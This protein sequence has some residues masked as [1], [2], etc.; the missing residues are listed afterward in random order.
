MSAP[1]RWQRTARPVEDWETPAWAVR[2]VEVLEDVAAPSTEPVEPAERVVA[3]TLGLSPGNLATRDATRGIS[4]HDLLV[5]SG[6]IVDIMRQQRDARLV[7]EGEGFTKA[8]RHEARKLTEGLDHELKGC[9]V[10]I[11]RDRSPAG[12]TLTMMKMMAATSDDPADWLFRLSR[13]TGGRPLV[14][15]DAT[16]I[17]MALKNLEFKR[18]RG[19]LQRVRGAL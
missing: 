18:A 17:V 1:T 9:V 15:P 8:E 3:R 19:I 13:M 6:R 2:D 7:V 10:E 11:S 5:L 4:D 12:R 16:E 14:E